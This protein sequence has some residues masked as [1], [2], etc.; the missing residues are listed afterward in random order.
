[1]LHLIREF[2]VVGA[3]RACRWFTAADGEEM[4]DID[5][6]LTISARSA[7]EA[8][9]RAQGI[10]AQGSDFSRWVDDPVVEE[11]DAAVTVA[12]SPAS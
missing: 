1:M 5:L 8:R 9:L 2:R 11:I 10:A 3:L 4:D 7:G 12:D 6:D